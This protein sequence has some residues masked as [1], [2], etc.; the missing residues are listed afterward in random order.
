M[1]SVT[2]DQIQAELDKTAES[3]RLLGMILSKTLDTDLM[4]DGAFLAQIDDLKQVMS[5]YEN[6]IHSF[7]K[8]LDE[9]NKCN[10]GTRGNLRLVKG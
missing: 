7:K 3:Y 2:K 10:P 8:V 1:K 9:R 5:D 6:S 4:L